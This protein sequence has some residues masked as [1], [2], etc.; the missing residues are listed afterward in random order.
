MTNG[1][2]MAPEAKTTSAP[3]PAEWLTDVQPET[4]RAEAARLLQIFAEETG[5]PPRL[6][7][8]SMVGFG[9]YV[10]RYDSGHSGE[11]LAVGFSPRKA[12][13]SIYIPAGYD[14]KSA[15]LSALGPHRLG[16]SCLYIKRLS[17]VHEAALRQII[18]DGLADIARRWPVTAE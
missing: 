5:F 3:F 1:S 2:T 8:G 16:K 18:R 6:W 4:R 7:G 14:G 15:L 17:A 12:D 10:Y 9:R 13:L 11:S